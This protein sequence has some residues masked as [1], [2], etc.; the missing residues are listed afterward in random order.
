MS[1]RPTPPLAA[2]DNLLFS[3][4]LR[5]YLLC[6]NFNWPQILQGY[7]LIYE[8]H[9]HQILWVL[10]FFKWVKWS[11]KVGRRVWPLGLHCFGYFG[12]PWLAHLFPVWTPIDPKFSGHI[13]R[14]VKIASS[15][16]YDAWRFL[17]WSNDNTKLWLATLTGCTNYLELVHL[18]CVISSSFKLR[19]TSKFV[20]MFLDM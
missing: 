9:F 15:K 19:L 18:C 16:F 11:Y 4:F 3:F 13:L 17:S 12:L 7:F 6:P 20:G 10:E 5:A 8:D 14:H 2:P 1:C